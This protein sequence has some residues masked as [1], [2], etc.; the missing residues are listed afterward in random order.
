LNQAFQIGSRVIA[1]QF[2]VEMTPRGVLDLLDNCA[3]DLVPGPYVQ[4]AS[5][6]RGAA[7]CTFNE[8]HALMKQVLEYITGQ[9]GKHPLSS[10]PETATHDDAKDV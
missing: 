2:H 4:T 6:I 3:A 9:G 8:I 10:P 1:M 5:A 7:P